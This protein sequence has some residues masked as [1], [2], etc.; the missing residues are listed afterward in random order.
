VDQDI[1]RWDEFF[2]PSTLATG[3]TELPNAIALLQED[4]MLYESTLQPPPA[5]APMRWPV[6]FL[7]SVLVLGLMNWLSGRISAARGN[8]I[9]LAW[10]SLSG[11][12]G[13][14]MVYFWFGTDHVVAAANANLLLFNPLFLLV[15]L[16]VLRRPVAGL[17]LLAGALALLQSLLPAPPGQ[18]SADVVAAFLPLNLWAVW[19]LLRHKGPA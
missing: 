2:I 16:Q 14:A 6:Y 12:A 15:N 9:A 13:A 4:V 1:S 10:L 18:Y 3:I 17:V 8:G 19:W 7:L 5:T 11:L